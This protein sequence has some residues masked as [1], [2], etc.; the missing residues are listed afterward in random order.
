MDRFNKLLTYI[1]EHENDTY[2]F[3]DFT[4][5]SITVTYDTDYESNNGLDE[6]DPNYEE[7]QSIVLKATE[8]N[9][10]FEINYHTLPLKVLCNGKE[11]I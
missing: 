1:H 2:T 7:Y 10:L 5:N 6:T 9:T 4:G 8:E 3:F 11:I